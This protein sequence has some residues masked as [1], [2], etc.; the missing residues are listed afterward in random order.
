MKSTFYAQFVKDTRSTHKGE[1]RLINATATAPRKP[2]PGAVLVKVSLEI[3]DA[4]FEPLTA[5]GVIE[6][7]FVGIP[8]V[9]EPEEVEE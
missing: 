9:V 8:V 6:A 4:A 2:E 1:A 7:G 3:P 5:E